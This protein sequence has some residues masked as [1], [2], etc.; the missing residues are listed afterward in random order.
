M[1]AKIDKRLETGL[2]ASYKEKDS[3]VLQETRRQLSE[4]FS[5]KRKR[6]DIPLLLTGTDF[7]KK[8]WRALAEIPFGTTVSYLQ[9]AEKIGNKKAVRAVAAANGANALSIFIPCHR[10]VGKNGELVGYA[11]GL[12]AKAKLLSLEQSLFSLQ[13]SPAP[14]NT[15]H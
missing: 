8:V 10:V 3:K 4:Y 6:F 14:D 9:L 12:R 15:V 7:Q 11:G 2:N 1:R 5:C 13:D